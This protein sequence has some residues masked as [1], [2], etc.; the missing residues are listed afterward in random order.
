MAVVERKSARFEGWD[1]CCFSGSSGCYT[2]LGSRRREESVESSP[3]HTVLCGPDQSR[4]RRKRGT[5]TQ[6]AWGRGDLPRGPDLLRTACLQL[7]LLRGG[8][9][10]GAPFSRRIRERTI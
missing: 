3:F 2:G 4:G 7:R 10:Y 5:R 1:A 8:T 6:A 9:R